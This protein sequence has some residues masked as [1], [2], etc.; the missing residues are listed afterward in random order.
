M[1]LPR[2][3]ILSG[4]AVVACF[5]I[6]A[7]SAGTDGAHV[8]DPLEAE[9]AR[10]SSYLQTNPSTDEMWTQVKQ[11]SGPVLERAAD[12]LHGGRRWLALSRLAAAQGNIAATKYVEGIP[13]AESR[14]STAFLAEWKRMGSDLTA[15]LATI[16]PDA[17]I[18]VHPAAVRAVLETALPQVKVYYEASVDFERA[19][20]APAGFFYLGYARAQR[21]LAA[22]CRTLSIP[23]GPTVR[24]LRLLDPELDALEDAVLRA[25]RPPAS[26]DRH[27]EFITLGSSLKEARELNAAGLRYGAALRYLQAALRFA[28]I[29]GDAAGIG[30]REMRAHVEE[31]D[32]R[33]TL[34]GVDHTL[35][36]LFLEIAQAD[37]AGSTADTASAVAIAVDTDVLPRYLALFE[38]A[39]PTRRM[40][41]PRVTVTLVRWPYT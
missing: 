24:E 31:W 23:A 8:A 6:S 37:L 28:P 1:R 38:P 2:R 15:E 5:L 13:A 19:T 34:G 12:A 4:A 40:P 17:A 14:D 26:I 20:D 3:G 7:I 33:L 9:I 21:D 11:V 35:G 32:R 18:D 22:F 27:A 29:R 10:W 16:P 30:A 36:R 41:T 25:Y 39:P